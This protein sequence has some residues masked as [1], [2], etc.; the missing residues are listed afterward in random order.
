MSPLSTNDMA[1]IGVGI[2][3]TTAYLFREQIF[4][5]SNNKT[6]PSLASKGKSLMETGDPRDF[7]AKMV[8]S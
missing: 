3:L 5:G 7:V 1:V 6:A 8:A 4:G 2:G